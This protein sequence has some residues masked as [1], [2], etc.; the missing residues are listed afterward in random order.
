VSG[1]RSKFPTISRSTVHAL[2]T[3]YRRGAL[4]TRVNPDTMGYVW[5]GEFDLNTLS[6]DGEIFESGKKKLRIQKYPQ[7]CGRG[8]K[9]DLHDTALTHATSLRRAYD[10]LS[11]HLHA[12][13]IFTYEIKYAKVCTR[14]YGAK[15]LRNDN[16][17]F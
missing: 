5:T 12:H 7:S 9:A 13:D 3:F 8:L 1:E 17:I 4:G 14:I 11:D 15:V 16:Q 2:R 6:V 10:M